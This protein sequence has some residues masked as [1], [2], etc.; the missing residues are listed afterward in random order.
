MTMRAVAV[1]AVAVV[2]MLEDLRRFAVSVLVV[3]R[4]MNWLLQWKQ[5]LSAS[6][7]VSKSTWPLTVVIDSCGVAMQAAQS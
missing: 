5:L 2:E 4:P 7:L 3:L 6:L 1:A